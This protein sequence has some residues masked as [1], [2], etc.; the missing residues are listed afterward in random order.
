MSY[1]QTHELKHS[2]LWVFLPNA[3]KIA[4]TQW[5]VLGM[6]VALLCGWCIGEFHQTDPP[7]T[8]PNLPKHTHSCTPVAWTISLTDLSLKGSAGMSSY[9]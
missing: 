5:M 7:D 3:M 1:P 8:L 2:I 6:V 4:F 9:F